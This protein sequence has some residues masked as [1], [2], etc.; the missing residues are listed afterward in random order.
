MKSRPVKWS[1][2]VLFVLG[3]ISVAGA[4]AGNRAAVHFGG[5]IND[6]TPISGTTA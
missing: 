3:L 2:S 1:V 6:Y 5:V 4:V